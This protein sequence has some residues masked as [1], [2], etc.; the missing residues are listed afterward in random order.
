MSLRHAIPV[1]VATLA[2]GCALERGDSDFPAQTFEDVGVTRDAGSN[3]DVGLGTGSGAGTM[4]GTW[5]QIHEASTCVVVDEQITWAWYLVDVEQEGRVLIE[6]RRQCEVT[7]SPVFGQEPTVPEATATSVDFFDVDN[8]L[9]SNLTEGGAY[10]SAT[11]VGLWGVQLENVLSDPVPTEAD[12][13]AVVDADDDGNPGVTFGSV[14]SECERYV[15]Q[16]SVVRYFGH[17]TTPNQIDGDSVTVTDTHVLGSSEP[18]CGIDPRITSN[19]QHSRFRMVRVDGLGESVNLDEDDDGTI[20][21]TEAEPWFDRL[22][23]RREPS[24]ENCN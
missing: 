13:P 7:L 4:T 11:E 15:A 24:P 12:D 10:T 8:G 6:S 3:R 23:E 18:L 20:T 17:F 21:C 2:C 9:V 16:R 14:G 1:L 19:D 22:I 5:L